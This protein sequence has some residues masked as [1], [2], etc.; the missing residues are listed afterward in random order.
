MALSTEDGRILF[1]D[2]QSISNPAN[3]STQEVNADEI[4]ACTLLAQMGGPASGISNRV[5]DFEVLTPQS[6]EGSPTGVFIIITGSSNGAVRVWSLGVSELQTQSVEKP[7]K[8][9]GSSE[10]ASARGGFT[11]KQIGQLIGTYQTSTRITCLKAFVMSGSPEEA[12][13][14]EEDSELGEEES[15]GDSSEDE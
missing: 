6:K 11:A 2:T 8:S 13:N 4:P 10:D 5:K 1:Y 15:S 12:G 7:A 9:N 3:G 14:E